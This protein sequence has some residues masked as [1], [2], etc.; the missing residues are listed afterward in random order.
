VRSR[1][2]VCGRVQPPFSVPRAILNTPDLA[3]GQERIVIERQIVAT[4]REIDRLVYVLYELTDEEIAI[5][6]AVAQ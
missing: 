6:E 1:T 2:P 5:V 4:E 3:A